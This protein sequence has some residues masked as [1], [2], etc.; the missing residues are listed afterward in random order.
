MYGLMLQDW[1]SIQGNNGTT[2]QVTQSEGDWLDASA[3]Q[4]IVFWLHCS[5]YLPNGATALQLAV[6]TAPIKSESAFASMTT[7][8]LVAGVQ[9]TPILLATANVP[10]AR[11]VRWQFNAVSTNTAVFATTFRLYAAANPRGG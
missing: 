2:N 9:V 8:T 7:F 10:V 4:D 3:Y 5:Q 1:I 6:Q 11:W